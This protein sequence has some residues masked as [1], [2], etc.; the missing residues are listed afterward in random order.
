MSLSRSTGKFKLVENGVK[1]AERYYEELVEWMKGVSHEAGIFTYGCFYRNQGV[2]RMSMYGSVT[3][4]QMFSREL[5]DEEMIDIT[6]C[7]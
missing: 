2:Q 5:S 4:A 1:N 6:S 7:K 3:D